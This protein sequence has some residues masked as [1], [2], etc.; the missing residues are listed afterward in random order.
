MHPRMMADPVSA[1]GRTS[2]A[3]P[4]CD[5]RGI[6]PGR[7]AA[8]FGEGRDAAHRYFPD[9]LPIGWDRR[10]TDHHVFVYLATAPTPWDFRLFLLRHIPLLRLLT[11][12]TIRVL[13]PKTLAHARRPYL[14][15]AR[16]HLLGTARGRKVDILEAVF[17]Q[18][19]QLAEPNAAPPYEH[20]E[21]DSA[22]FPGPRFRAMY[23][24]WLVDP[25]ALWMADSLA[26]SD[27]ID[28]GHGRIE[29]VPADAPIPASLP[30]GD[31]RL[32]PAPPTARAH[33]PKAA[34][35]RL[36]LSVTTGR[37]VSA[38]AMIRKL[39]RTTSGRPTGQP[40]FQR[41]SPWRQYGCVHHSSAHAG[42]PRIERPTCR[43]AAAISRCGS[44]GGSL[45]AALS[46]A[47]HVH[48]PVTDSREPW[49][50]RPRRA[51]RI[52]SRPCPEG[53]LTPW[54]LV[55]LSLSLPSASVVGARRCCWRRCRTR[56]WPGCSGGSW[57]VLAGGTGPVA[58]PEVGRH[59]ERRPSRPR[60]SI[61][62]RRRQG[63]SLRSARVTRQRLRP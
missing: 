36:Q 53:S 34:T 46:A 2:R 5:A 25:R 16:E 39:A 31:R 62:A 12:W 58:G 15:A 14:H 59:A 13:L 40:R 21:R 29:C 18:R 57:G 49:R 35:P 7:A 55:S 42:H 3:G 10:S 6:S 19:R 51:R 38:A 4:G 48:E 1:V 26:I 33:N 54:L 47:L 37:L 9:K 41:L 43:Q 56:S 44:R 17:K 60:V 28:R 30:P 23:Q 45:L 52:P 27:A 63:A 50:E 8:C 32:T 20:Y 61:C 24:Q 11:Q 22:F